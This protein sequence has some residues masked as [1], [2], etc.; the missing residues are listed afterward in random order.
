MSQK[1]PQA[2]TA[3]FVTIEFR[4]KV[5]ETVFDKGERFRLRS[6]GAAGKS[7]IDAQ[8]NGGRTFTLQGRE[9]PL[10]LVEIVYHGPDAAIAAQED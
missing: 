10:G 4:R 2:S 9:V 1:I 6:D 7:L 8:R 3:E 5:Q